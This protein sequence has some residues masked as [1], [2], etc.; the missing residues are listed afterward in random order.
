MQS[1][2]FSILYLI[3]FAFIVYRE[4]KK[5]QSQFFIPLAT[6]SSFFLI[7][8]LSIIE[9]QNHSF[10]LGIVLVILLLIYLHYRWN[11][12]ALING[13]F[14]NLWF[15]SFGIYLTFH[16]YQ[17]R[18]A[19]VLG[20]LVIVLILFIALAIFGLISLI[21]LLYWNGLIVLKREGRSLGNLLTLLLA[22]FLTV[23]LLLNTFFINKLPEFLVFLLSILPFAL[24]Y[25]AIAFL[26]FLTISL[27]YQLNRPKPKQDFIIVLGAGLINGETVTPLLAKRIDRA[28]DF[29]HRQLKQ[30]GHPI[31]IILSG[32]QGADEKVS[33]AFA[34]KQYALSQGIPDED[35]LLEDQS[36]TTQTNMSLSKKI[37]ESYG[38]DKPR[39]IF[40]SNNYHIFR[41]AIFAR[42]SGLFADGIGAKTALYYLPNAF[43]REFIAIIAMNRKKHFIIIG[44]AS[45]FLLALAAITLMV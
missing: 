18:D 8:Y 40:S 23:L 44:I 14:F 24:F 21:I 26:N 13:L 7:I 31:K 27:I 11:K 38:L 22:I 29:Y 35:L 4:R 34:M 36:T 20:I 6:W 42:Q 33:E 3:V 17:T 5:E 32:G 2:L 15:I 37:I 30:T 45:A 10:Y 39:V 16:F 41:A 1:L 43:L 28:I 12:T 25:F 19:I 9:I